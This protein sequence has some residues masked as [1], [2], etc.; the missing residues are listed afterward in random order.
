VRACDAF[1]DSG[2]LFQFD[3]AQD[4]DVLAKSIIDT[5]I[6]LG[7][8]GQLSIALTTYFLTPHFTP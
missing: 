1:K 5:V 2:C 6:P 4:V 3:A 7:G 8:T